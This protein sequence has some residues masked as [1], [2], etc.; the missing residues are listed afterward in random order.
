MDIPEAMEIVASIQNIAK[1]VALDATEKQ[2]Y[3]GLVY[4]L[5]DSKPKRLFCGI[6][7]TKEHVTVEFDRGVELQ[8]KDHLL[9]GSGKLR[10]HL[11]ISVHSEIGSK[12]VR[13]FIEESYRLTSPLK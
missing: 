6:F 2:M 11:T 9:E 10:R 13:Q 1:M 12:R 8:D 3:G 5:A 7:I 4:E